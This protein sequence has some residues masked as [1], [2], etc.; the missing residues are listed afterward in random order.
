MKEKTKSRRRS[1]SLYA[2]IVLTTTILLCSCA[3]DLSEAELFERAETSYENGDLASSIIDL[4]NALKSNP[5]N[6]DA[7]VMLGRIYLESGNSPSAEK[8]LRR[9]IEL[10]FPVDPILVPL[11]Q[12]LLE[13]G[14]LT[15]LL[16]E[17]T[18]SNTMSGAQQAE[19]HLLR[20]KAY[21]MEGEFFEASNEFEAAMTASSDSTAAWEGQALLAMSQQQWD[22]AR[23]W[24]VKIL[25][26]QP[27]ATLIWQLLGD[28]ER[29]VGDE[30][31]AEVAYT[32]AIDLP[33]AHIETLLKRALVRVAL[34]N[35][36]D[37]EK[38]A[39]SAKKAA[40]KSAETNYVMGVVHFS[41]QQYAQAQADFE[42][43]LRSK[44]DHAFAQFYLGASH[45]AQNQLNQADQN[46]RWFLRH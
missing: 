45:F 15:T 42:Q 38:D 26:K 5:Q 27:T 29:I 2:G 24:I 11:A 33:P 25:E 23:T 3:G 32:K 10:G 31:Q 20:G 7:R 8:E 18:I 28:L 46:L 43:S 41:L 40:P 16:E 34:G 9:A 14:K 35:Y 39:K 37:A 36:A 21:S 22:E 30:A 1:N 12:A 4:K 17:M 13:Q 19:L 6:S 44:P